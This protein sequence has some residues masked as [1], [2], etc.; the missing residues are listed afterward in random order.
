MK[1]EIQAKLKEYMKA[2]NQAA[3]DTLRGLLTA[4]Q[5]EEIAK[6][7]EPL[8]TEGIV[9][10]IQRE[11]K[12]LKEEREFAVQ[13]QRTDDIARI[14]QQSGILEG[15]LPQQ[16]DATQIEKILLDLKGAQPGINM[17]VA[18]K[19]LKERYAGQYDGKV[20]S[21]VAKRVLG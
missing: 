1:A 13:A 15:L 7:T 3:M 10:V 9:A 2:R 12:K 4:I 11:A 18:M 21:E 17:G 20:A 5:Y 6:K 14:D 16:M 19:H 8:P